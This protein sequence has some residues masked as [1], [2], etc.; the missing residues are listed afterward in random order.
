MANRAEVIAGLSAPCRFKP[1]GMD[2]LTRAI[3]TAGMGPKGGKGGGRAASVWQ[4]EHLKNILL[5][6]PG[7]S[8]T[9]GP[10]AAKA[11][12]HLRPKQNYPTLGE[13][14]VL[15]IMTPETDSLAGAMAAT[16]SMEWQLA[17]CLDPLMAW[18]SWID[19]KGEERRDVYLPAEVWAHQ[20]QEWTPNVRGARR[21]T[22]IDI[23][24]LQATR[25][26]VTR[27]ELPLDDLQSSSSTSPNENAAPGRA[28]LTRIQ[29]HGSAIPEGNT[30]ENRREREI[31]QP[32]VS[33]GPGSSSS[34]N[35]KDN[36]HGRT[37]HVVTE[38]GN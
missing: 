28:A 7:L 31:S 30:P 8:S 18:T 21:L 3:M 1:S 13:F 12:Q 36:Q 33:R 22:I 32:L 6:L 23:D 17:M 4:P 14:L 26:L 24:V 9:D 27:P 37:P 35:R 16:K 38:L 25:G 15:L 29:D 10:E 11:L 19:F 20:N 34:R 5:G 2:L